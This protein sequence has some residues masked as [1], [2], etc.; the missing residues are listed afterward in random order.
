[1]DAFANVS[2][3]RGVARYWAG[4]LREAIADL[5]AASD[6]TAHGWRHSI[7]AVH[8][9]H[10]L[11][12]L[13][14]GALDEARAV[15]S[16]IDESWSHQTGWT[17]ALEARGR[18]ELAEGRTEQALECFL[19][20]GRHVSLNPAMAGA[21]R[22]SVAVALVRLGRREEARELVE[23]ELRAARRFGAPRA[24][25]NALR[26]LGMTHSGERGIEL[27]R[28]SLEVL[29]GSEAQ[30]SRART[31]VELGSALRRDGQRI[32]ARD[33]L[34]EA[35]DLARS[36]CANA[37]ADRA[38]KELQQAGGRMRRTALTGIESL[39]PSELRVAR[40][41]AE[42]MTNREIAEALFVTVKAVEWHLKNAYP[43][44]GISSRRDL[45][46]ALGTQVPAAV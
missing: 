23:E 40:L 18:V 37:T 38:L 2:Y 42:G 13:E 32:E 21:W 17:V 30:L 28:E 41:A 22:S 33:R 27:L 8:G 24:L 14:T 31:L 39:T 12:L 6:A 26:S 36:L 16:R 11:A 35:I 34:R 3:H 25:G 4:R 1:M 29:E 9:F 5:S 44:L 20:R 10:V 7:A 19:A 46:E 45:P 43:K 15:A